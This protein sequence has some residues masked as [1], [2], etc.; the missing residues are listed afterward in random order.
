[1]DNSSSYGF[2][3]YLG[4]FEDARNSSD[5]NDSTEGN[6]FY[7][8]EISFFG[9]AKTWLDNSCSHF[10]F[11]YRSSTQ[12]KFIDPRYGFTSYG[13]SNT[14]VDNL[15]TNTKDDGTC[16]SMKYNFNFPK[17]YKIKQIAI[18]K[19]QNHGNVNN[20]ELNSYSI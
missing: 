9:T 16:R 4:C 19:G 12:C 3:E 15:I 6:I 13:V 18:T 10:D 7:D 1:M 14:G 20:W 2:S 5:I 17:T 11:R 8:N